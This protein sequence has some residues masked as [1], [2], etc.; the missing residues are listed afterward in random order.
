M[1]PGSLAPESE[2][3]SVLP[4]SPELTVPELL[5]SVLGVVGAGVLGAGVLEPPEDPPE[6]VFPELLPPLLE[7]PE[8]DPPELPLSV[9]AGVVPAVGVVAAAA[10]ACGFLT[11]DTVIVSIVSLPAASFTE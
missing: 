1:L 10:G 4:L 3:V 7:P 6:L 5:P 11:T 2:P 9:L 8:E